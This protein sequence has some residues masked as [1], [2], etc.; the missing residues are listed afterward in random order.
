MECKFVSLSRST[1]ITSL[2][3]FRFDS[4][5]KKNLCFKTIVSL[6]LEAF[7]T[8]FCTFLCRTHINWSSKPSKC[9]CWRY[10]FII[11]SY[12]SRKFVCKIFAEPVVYLVGE[13]G[14]G[15]G[16][17]LPG[18]RIRNRTSSLQAMF[19]FRLYVCQVLIYEVWDGKVGN[20]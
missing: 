12:I 4:S 2:T 11:I 19:W 7:K 5:M 10:Y 9:W 13:R 14:G 6:R 16:C 8:V 15:I 17:R 18:C 3:T 1:I 20:F